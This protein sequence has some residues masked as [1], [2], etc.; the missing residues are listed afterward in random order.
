VSSLSG[1]TPVFPM[2]MSK[3]L[4]W[5]VH[6][7]NCRARRDAVQDMV[8]STHPDL[9]CL[10]ETKKAII[11]H[12]M[13]MSMLGAEFDEFIELLMDGTRSGILLAWKGSVCQHLNSRIDNFSLSVK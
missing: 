3:T 10:Q 8:A 4:I 7:L 11:S 5:N 1:R 13:V 12:R 9:V 6:G 2:D